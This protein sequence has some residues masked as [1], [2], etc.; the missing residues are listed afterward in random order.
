M[1]RRWKTLVFT[2]APRTRERGPVYGTQIGVLNVGLNVNLVVVLNHHHLHHRLPHIVD[3]QVL[4][5][6]LVLIQVAGENQEVHV[7]QQL[8]IALVVL[9][10]IKVV[11]VANQ[12]IAVANLVLIVVIIHK[13]FLV[14]V[15][16]LVK[17]YMT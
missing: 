4:V 10:A 13:A 17:V 16:L 6:Q 15:D 3:L 2:G 12:E 1:G 11:L 7:A 14:T 8:I 9:K 5:H